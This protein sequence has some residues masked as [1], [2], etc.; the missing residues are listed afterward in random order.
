VFLLPRAPRCAS[1][2]VVRFGG[3]RCYDMRLERSYGAIHSR[4]DAARV[5]LQNENVTNHT[6]G[7]TARKNIFI[8][9]KK[10]PQCD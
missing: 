9:G 3:A 5:A 8:E 1:S 2:Q 7:S 4:R 10:S 6:G